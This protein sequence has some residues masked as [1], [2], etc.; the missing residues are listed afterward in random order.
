MF[1]HL[2]HLISYLMQATLLI[3]VTPP[4]YQQPLRQILGEQSASLSL[5]QRKADKL[6]ARK[7]RY[8][9]AI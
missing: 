8:G 7:Q 5:M 2:Q 6:Y 9:D 1:L 4:L 3:R